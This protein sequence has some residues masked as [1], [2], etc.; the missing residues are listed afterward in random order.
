MNT[1][2][3]KFGKAS[4]ETGYTFGKSGPERFHGKLTVKTS[5]KIGD[6]GE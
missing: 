4:V 6:P 2:R 3:D 1:L 5:G